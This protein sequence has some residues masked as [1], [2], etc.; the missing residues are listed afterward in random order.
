MDDIMFWVIISVFLLLLTVGMCATGCGPGAKPSQNKTIK[1]EEVVDN[2]KNTQETKVVQ[3]STWLILGQKIID[4]VKFLCI[5]VVVAFFVYR[6]V[7]DGK[8]GW[9]GGGR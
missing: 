9:L 2:S 3:N 5:F 1:A 8:F 7:A 4:S 6:L